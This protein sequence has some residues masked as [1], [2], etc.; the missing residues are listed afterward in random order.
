MTV[1]RAVPLVCAAS[2][3]LNSCGGNPV[4]ASSQ[5]PPGASIAITP[6]P[7]SL[8][9]GATIGLQALMKSADG[10]AAPVTASWLTDNPAVARVSSNGELSA[11]GPGGVTVFA[12]SSGLSASMA[13]RVL[14]VF[15]GAWAGMV[16]MTA[17][18]PASSTSCGFTPIGYVKPIRLTL[19]QT[20]DRLSGSIEIAEGT[21]PTSRVAAVTGVISLAGIAA[22]HVG[23]RQSE[24]YFGTL[25]VIDLSVTVDATGSALTGR[26]EQT[27][28]GGW[29]PVNLVW[30]LVDV[31]RGS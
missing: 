19:T 31:K 27:S 5:P 8:F 6:Q 24:A 25:E 10:T 12:V 14:P 20:E 2:I 26:L 21:L 29:N 13:T 18:I 1:W 22:I 7:G 30:D 15:E 28:I 3:A 4:G 16:K 11:V 23:P 9:V 17:C